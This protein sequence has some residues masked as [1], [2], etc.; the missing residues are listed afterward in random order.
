L[1][2]L[3]TAAV[4]DG[5]A[6]VS[7]RAVN[8]TD[9]SVAAADE[10]ST[11]A[12]ARTQQAS[13]QVASAPP[14]PAPNP[15]ESLL[16]FP[17]VSTSQLGPLQ[18]QGHACM[19]TGNDVLCLLTVYANDTDVSVWNSGDGGATDNKGNT[20]E[21]EFSV[22]RERPTENQGT[23]VA[24]VATPFQVFVKGVPFSADTIARLVVQLNYRASG[25]GTNYNEEFVLRGLPIVR[26]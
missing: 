18:A 4:L 5:R 16:A 7:A 11:R 25:Q 15:V 2:V 9:G 13:R 6:V 19:R 10:F 20:R 17:V 8:I 12:G 3:G 21:L 23:V 24:G 26:P 14:P 22:G 1:V